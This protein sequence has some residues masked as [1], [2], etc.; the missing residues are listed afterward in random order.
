MR[1]SEHSGGTSLFLALSLAAAA[2]T[3]DGKPPE[4][5]LAA[6]FTQTVAA[7]AARSGSRFIAAFPN[8]L[9][10]RDAARAFTDQAR[11][12]EAVTFLKETALRTLSGKHDTVPFLRAKIGAKN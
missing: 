3:E 11:D 6:R 4:R 5:M 2:P 1:M 8:V 10:L 9:Q 12:E 7:E